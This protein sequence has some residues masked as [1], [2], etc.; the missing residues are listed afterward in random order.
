[1]NRW[2][3][4]YTLAVPLAFVVTAAPCLG[5]HGGGGGGF[6][7]SAKNRKVEEAA[8]RKVT[9]DFQQLGWEV[10]SVEKLRIG[11]DLLCVKGDR[12]RKV[13]VKGVSG[14]TPSF[15]LTAGEFRAAD[16]ADFELHVVVNALS[17]TPHVKKWTGKRM[18]KD[19]SFTPIQLQAALKI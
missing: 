16:D 15:M 6:G 14:D 1:M 10:E 5:F 7:D 13:E 9:K 4:K 8:V 2:I 3:R 18:K 17:K 11:F 12:M 19:F